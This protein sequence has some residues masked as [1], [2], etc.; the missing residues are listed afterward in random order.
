MGVKVKVLG[1][2]SLTLVLGLVV[3][4][5]LVR[6]AMLV[7]VLP[8]NAVVAA[9]TGA[10]LATVDHV[11]HGQVRRRPRPLPLNIDAI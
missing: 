10:G 1:G 6:D 5:G 11:L 4:A 2:K 8:D 9:M 3:V 7:G